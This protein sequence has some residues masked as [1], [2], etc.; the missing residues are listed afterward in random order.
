[1]TPKKKEIYY[2]KEK[3]KKNRKKNI[4]K[5]EDNLKNINNLNDF[6]KFFIEGSIYK[7]ALSSEN[8]INKKI[9]DAIL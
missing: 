5:F 8:I 9:T 3:I 7:T 1:M 4:K 6:N 2:K